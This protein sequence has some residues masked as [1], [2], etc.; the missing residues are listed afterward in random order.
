MKSEYFW[1]TLRI[2]LEYIRNT[3]GTVLVYFW[4]TK[5]LKKKFH[6][7][8]CSTFFYSF[9]ACY[10]CCLGTFLLLTLAVLELLCL[11]V[12]V[13]W[14][15]PLL[16]VLM[17]LTFVVIRTKSFL[18]SSLFRAR[19][20]TRLFRIFLK[21]RCFWQKLLQFLQLFWNCFDNV[22]NLFLIAEFS[23]ISQTN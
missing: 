2:K 7:S 8:H 5:I 15:F 12:C 19:V 4:N 23:S 13:C 20:S 6:F 22:L 14:R 11:C 10:F 17:F 21:M 9:F 16:L 18:L 1:N 3:F